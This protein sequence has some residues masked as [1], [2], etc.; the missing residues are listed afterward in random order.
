VISVSVVFFGLF[1]VFGGVFQGGGYTRSYMM[2]NILRLWGLRLPLSWL[3]GYTWGLGPAGVWW[4]MFVSNIVVFAAA[5]WIYR[6]GK[7]AQKLNL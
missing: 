4:A 6:R 5:A 2:L 7:W 1:T 3:L